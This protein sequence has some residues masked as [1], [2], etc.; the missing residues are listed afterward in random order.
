[1]KRERSKTDLVSDL[2]SGDAAAVT[3]GCAS[4]IG[5]AHLPKGRALFLSE[6]LSGSSLFSF[7][8]G[9]ELSSRP[10]M[11]VAVVGSTKNRGLYTSKPR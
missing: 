1:M 10:R 3:A 11:K 9:G 8:G 6:K 5:G 2:V 4:V 7:K